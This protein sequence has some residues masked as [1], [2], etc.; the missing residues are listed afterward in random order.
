MDVVDGPAVSGST[1]HNPAF[2]SMERAT[3]LPRALVRITRPPQSEERGRS[4]MN[5]S[6]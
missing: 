6:A 3:F 5:R 1:S 2:G 4:I